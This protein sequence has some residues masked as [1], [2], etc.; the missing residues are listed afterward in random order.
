MWARQHSDSYPTR[1]P[2]A[3]H[4]RTPKSNV[5]TLEIFY[6]PIASEQPGQPA[7]CKMKLRY[8]APSM[9]RSGNRARRVRKKK[10][11]ERRE[12]RYFLSPRDRGYWPAPAGPWETANKYT[13][14]SIKE[15]ANQPPEIILPP[16]LDLED[17]YEKTVSHFRH[18][19]DAAKGRYRIKRLG[20][21]KIEYISPAAALML[22]SEVDRWKE[23]TVR[24][25]AETNTWHPDI[26][27]LLCEMGFFELLGLR[28]PPTPESAGSVT[29]LNFL[30]GTSEPRD[31]GKI[32]QQLRINIEKIVG[33]GV[34][35]KH[36][37]F[38]SLSEA[39]TNVI[40]HAYPDET[41]QGSGK[42][43]W[44][45]ASYDSQNRE[46][47]VLIYDQ[48]VGIPATLP[49]R[50]ANFEKVRAAFNSWSDSQKIEAAATYGRSSTNLPERGKGLRNL[51]EFAKAHDAGRL[52][53]Y[54]RCGLYRLSHGSGNQIETSRRDHEVSAGGT[55]I[56]WSVRL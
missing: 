46:L 13:R 40:H 44:L 20:F 16:R 52:S 2:G 43:W 29:F 27:R 21:E 45:S 55:L 23:K 30:R 9:N 34:V 10:W 15:A 5:E 6:S 53:I 4:K 28:K 17:N 14:G 42:P 36:V 35:R 24:M 19:R 38:D 39:I 32:A 1:A 22:A 33:E 49:T 50:W 8:I 51:Q 48:G 31:K 37:L 11:L 12:R 3:A 47:T 7:C 54:S 26:K 25:R 41:N 56:E 18:V